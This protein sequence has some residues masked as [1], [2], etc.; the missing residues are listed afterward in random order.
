LLLGALSFLPQIATLVMALFGMIAGCGSHALGALAQIPLNLIFVTY[1]LSAVLYGAIGLG[2]LSCRIGRA[3][4]S[5]LLHP[6]AHGAAVGYAV[7]RLLLLGLGLL[8]L[9]IDVA[10]LAFL[11]Q[12]KAK[13]VFEA[14]ANGVVA[15]VRKLDALPRCA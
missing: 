7:P 5:L 2:L 3:G 13:E 6:R 12:P 10:A 11:F 9:V 4:W 14:G 1:F 15:G 8:S